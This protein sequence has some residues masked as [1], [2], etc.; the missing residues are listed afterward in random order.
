[1]FHFRWWTQP[2]SKQLFLSSKAKATFPWALEIIS[3]LPCCSMCENLH[4]LIC[5]QINKQPWVYSWSLSWLYSF[6][7]EFLKFVCPFRQTWS[8]ALLSVFF[9]SH[10]ILNPQEYLEA[11]PRIG[12][13]SPPFIMFHWP[14]GITAL[15]FQTQI[16]RLENNNAD[17]LDSNQGV[18]VSSSQSVYSWE[19]PLYI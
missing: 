3:I 18:V 11:V 15:T 4:I 2:G 14:Q 5:S 6:K 17:I 13:G 8:L 9:S 10:L 16:R 12:T 1:M 7:F 19:S